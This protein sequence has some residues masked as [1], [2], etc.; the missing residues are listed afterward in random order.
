MK[1]SSQGTARSSHSTV[2]SSV[3]DH[4]ILCRTSFQIVLKPTCRIIKMRVLK[5]FQF[6][7]RFKMWIIFKCWFPKENSNLPGI[8]GKNTNGIITQGSRC[9]QWQLT[10]PVWG[11]KPGL[12]WWS[13]TVDS[14]SRTSRSASSCLAVP[15]AVF[16]QGASR[17]AGALS[18]YRT[19][20]SDERVRTCKSC[21]RLSQASGAFILQQP[22]EANGA[23]YSPV[24][25]ERKSGC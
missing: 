22:H 3:S 19:C 2:L 17:S 25:G 4:L 12:T 13:L 5:C 1:L 7:E 8:P 15:P 6:W 21:Q 14:L 9:A 18:M 23:N 16:T 11:K 10:S 20:C 24:I